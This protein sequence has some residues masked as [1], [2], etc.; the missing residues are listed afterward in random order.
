MSLLRV[1]ATCLY[2]W[3]SSVFIRIAATVC[4]NDFISR[5]R[6]AD[7]KFPKHVLER[8]PELNLVFDKY[9]AGFVIGFEA[10]INDDSYPS[11]PY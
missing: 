11:E 8:R 4:V 9:E 1:L 5:N 7:E 2:E 6:L 3:L 10:G